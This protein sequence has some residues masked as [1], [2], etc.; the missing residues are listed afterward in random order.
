M[1]LEP[2]NAYT[3][4]VVGFVQFGTHFFTR[5]PLPS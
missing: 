3:V 1:I 4:V 2:E 5:N